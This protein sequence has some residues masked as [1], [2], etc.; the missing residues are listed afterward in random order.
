MPTRFSLH[1]VLVFVVLIGLSGL[2]PLPV[3]R[4]QQQGANQPG[5]TWNERQLRD[6]V[7]L[8]RVGRKL[9]PT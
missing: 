2:T 1:P 4:A 3:A 6:V 8:A 7:D 5:T 9:T